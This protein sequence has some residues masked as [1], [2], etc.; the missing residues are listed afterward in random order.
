MDV[1]NRDYAILA[2]I[3]EADE[4]IWKSMIRDRLQE[5]ESS[6][7]GKTDLSSQTVGRRI[8]VMYD[9]GM[10]DTTIVDTPGDTS[11]MNIG[12]ILTD[13]G[14]DAL[15]QKRR[16]ILGAYA[17][18]ADQEDAVE[19]VDRDVLLHLLDDELGFTG[20]EFDTLQE[21][22]TEELLMFALLYHT[23]RL[24]A[25]KLDEET[26]AVFSEIIHRLGNT[27]LLMSTLVAVVCDG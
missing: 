11:S 22:D 24:A 18:R 14:L 8:N 27:G 13:K 16:D 2:C 7:P 23:K 12:Y 1:D 4:P 10:V 9:R 20:E 6:F 26:E 5:D 17:F 21:C 19:F 25:D 3:A 15:S